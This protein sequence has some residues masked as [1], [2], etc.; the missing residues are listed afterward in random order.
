M[1]LVEQCRLAKRRQ[2]HSL[3]WL[4]RWGLAGWPRDLTALHDLLVRQ[5]RAVRLG[6]DV[7]R[8][9]A[10]ASASVPPEDV[11]TRVVSR[12]REVLNGEG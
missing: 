2:T 11:L 3:G 12:V 5:G 8:V 7:A 1:I 6:E 9:P 4:R 10:S